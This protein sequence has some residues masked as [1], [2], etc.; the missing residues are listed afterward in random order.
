MMILHNNRIHISKKKKGKK[1]KKEKKKAKGKKEVH[2][3]IDSNKGSP[4][5]VCLDVS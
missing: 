4:E 5:I 3:R 1:E 2:C